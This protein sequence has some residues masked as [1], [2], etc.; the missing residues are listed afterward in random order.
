MNIHL[1][2]L[3]LI[4]SCLFLEAK[5]T[6]KEFKPQVAS[7]QSN[8]VKT[9]K[10]DKRWELCKLEPQKS[11]YDKTKPS[12]LPTTPLKSI[13][14]LGPKVYIDVQE[15]N[16]SSQQEEYIDNTEGTNIDFFGTNIT[17]NI[18]QSM[19]KAAFEPKNQAGVIKFFDTMAQSEYKEFLDNLKKISSNLSLN[20]WGVYMLV[21][22]LSNKVYQ[23][24]DSSKL[25]RWFVLNKLGYGVKVGVSN[26]KIILMHYAKNIYHAPNCTFEGKKYYIL[27]DAKD[28]S[29]LYVYRDEPSVSVKEFDF[30]LEKLPLISKDIRVKDIKFLYNGNEYVFKIPYNKNLVDF[31]AT[32]PVVGYD[33]YLNAAM[34]EATYTALAKSF[35]EHINSKRSS[36]AMDFVLHFIQNAFIYEIDSTQFG[37][38][39]TMFAQESLVYDKSDCED[40]VVLFAYL[41]KRFFDVEI[42]ALKYDDHISSALYIPMSGDKVKIKSKDFIIAD[43]SYAN[44]SIGDG[45]QKYKNIAP[46]DY[47]MMSK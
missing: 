19:T 2:G 46:K 12:T 17:I 35:R 37:K 38:Q 18:P 39:K 36:E 30:S 11:F 24:R 9:D 47:I 16:I 29:A 21:S 10:N 20:D 7:S 45:M 34:E 14:S 27:E 33:I 43:P 5:D 13:E 8:A 31:M 4:Y 40:R 42:A 23:D 26:S 44:A 1:V 22:N 25:F 32:Y 41:V 28:I 15:Q 3:F 6:F